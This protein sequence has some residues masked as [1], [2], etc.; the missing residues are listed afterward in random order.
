MSSF[1]ILQK[2]VIKNLWYNDL[3]GAD[4]SKAYIFISELYNIP[5]ILEA[6]SE[7]LWLNISFLG[8]KAIEFKYWIISSNLDNIS[9]VFIWI[10]DRLLI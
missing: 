2:I 10:L 6:I 3:D 1:L 5:T 8:S 7:R 9:I 4:Y